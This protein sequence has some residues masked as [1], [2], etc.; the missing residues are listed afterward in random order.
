MIVRRGVQPDLQKLKPSQTCQHQTT[1]RSSKLS[2]VLLIILGNFPGIGDVCDPLY[3]L[4][5]S[6][7]TWTW[8]T[9]YQ[10]LFN[11]TKLLIKSDLCMKFYNDTKPFYLKMYTSRVGLGAALLQTREGKHARKTWCL[12][13]QFP[14]P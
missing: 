12:T 13:T 9:S 3:K 4:T 2:F 8:N 7:A 11:K 10:S 1:K 14:I 5:S 6:K